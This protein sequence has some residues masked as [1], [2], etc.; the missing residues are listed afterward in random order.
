MEKRADRKQ[1]TEKITFNEVDSELETSTLKKA[2][3]ATTLQQ[4]S[5][6]TAHVVL[7]ATGFRVVEIVYLI[8]IWTLGGTGGHPFLSDW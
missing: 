3:I 8:D 5:N 2:K 7:E 6:R 1:K 4:K